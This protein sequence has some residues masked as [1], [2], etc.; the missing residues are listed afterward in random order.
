[1][2]IYHRIEVSGAVLKSAL[3]ILLKD[4]AVLVEGELISKEISTGVKSDGMNTYTLISEVAAVLIKK[5]R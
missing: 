3:P 4:R 1:M 5:I 2:T